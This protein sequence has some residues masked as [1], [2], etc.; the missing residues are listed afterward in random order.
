MS[1]GEKAHSLSLFG[2]ADENEVS[3]H[4]DEQT[5]C[6]SAAG[7]LTSCDCLQAFSMGKWVGQLASGLGLCVSSF[8]W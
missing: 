2:P 3:C 4:C 7:L 5:R 6:Q 1:Y 8:R